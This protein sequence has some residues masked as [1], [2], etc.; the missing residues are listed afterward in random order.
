L[1]VFFDN[2]ERFSK[3]AIPTYV[4]EFRE[5][6]WLEALEVPEPRGARKLWRSQ[7]SDKGGRHAS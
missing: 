5:M 3:R 6:Q 7:R 2:V 4:Y 1:P